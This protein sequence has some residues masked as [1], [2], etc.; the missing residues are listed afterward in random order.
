MVIASSMSVTVNRPARSAASMSRRARRAM[1]L[2][3]EAMARPLRIQFPGAVYHIMARVNHGRPIFK[4]DRD[5]LRWLQS[6][7]EAC[8]KTGWRVHAYALTR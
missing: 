7:G 8:A 1:P 4:D 2:P 3:E 6:L 5:R